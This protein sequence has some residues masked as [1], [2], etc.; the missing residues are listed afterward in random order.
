MR[1]PAEICRERVPGASGEAL[2]GGRPNHPPPAPASSRVLWR[3]WQALSLCP[4]PWL[5]A[6][7]T[8]TTG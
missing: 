5:R 4:L 7:V 8:H 3:G 2:E 6:E 1:Q